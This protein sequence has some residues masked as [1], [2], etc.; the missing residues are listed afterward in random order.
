MKNRYMVS[1]IFNAIWICVCA[2]AA[3]L[4]AIQGSTLG[5]VCSLAGI[6]FSFVGL[7]LSFVSLARYRYLGR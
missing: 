7:F 4:N 3:V 6:L 2:I 1:L 5:L